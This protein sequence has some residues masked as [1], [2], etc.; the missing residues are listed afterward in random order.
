MQD[1]VVANLLDQVAELKAENAALSAAAG[2][3]SPTMVYFPIAG[4]GEVARLIA[5]A[6]GLTLNEVAEVPAG[7]T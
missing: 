1:R 6:G 4:R 7:E 3:G 2:G 5:A